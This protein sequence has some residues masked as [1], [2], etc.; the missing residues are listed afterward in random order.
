MANPTTYFGWVMPT[1]SSLV[2]NLPADFNTF[3][4]GVDTSLQ[5][6]LG[7]TTGQVLSK[8]SN[9]NMDFTWVTPTDQTPLTTKGDLFTFTTVDARLAVG[10]NGE[11]LVADSAAT[12][13]LRYQSNFAAGKNAI[14]NGAFNVWQRGTSISLTNGVEVYTADRFAAKCSFTAGTSTVTQQTFTPGTAPA[15]GYESQYFA[16]LTCGSTSTYGYFTQRI[17]DVRTFAGQTIT[18]SLWAK[19]SAAVTLS[20]TPVQNFGSGGSS[21]VNG[22]TGNATLT[23]SWARYSFTQTLASIS[24][25]TVGTSSFVQIYAEFANN[26]NSATI[27]TWG[28]QVEASNTATAFQT[29]TGTLQGELAACQR[30]Y[31]RSPF[32][33]TYTILGTGSAY[34]TANSRIFIPLL[35]QMRTQP[36]T[37]DYGGT[38]PF[39]LYD[40]TNVIGPFAGTG[41]TLENGFLSS[42]KGAVVTVVPG[43][44]PL[45]AFRPYF[46][47]FN[48]SGNTSQYIGFGAEL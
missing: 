16:R 17:E 21:P 24:G 48:G 20:V 14:I 19:A 31:W 44:T 29:A 1:S 40:G 34:S 27:D 28:W 6:L 42:S 3:G 18:I 10:N 12:T 46:L 43:G 39:S 25:K 5:D 26:M 35:V 8:T 23:T 13:G 2:T 9:T 41:L 11:T 7:G 4:Q 32:E 38:T 22:S 36:S 15:A 33:S 47:I 45:T 30:Y 37:L